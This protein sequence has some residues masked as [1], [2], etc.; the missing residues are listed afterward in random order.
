MDPGINGIDCKSATFNRPYIS[1]HGQ[2][3]ACCWVTGSDEEATFLAGHGLTPGRYNIH[4]RPL[5]EILVD[6][7]FARL[8]ARAWAADSLATCRHKCGK[9]LRNKPNTLWDGFRL[10][11][12][13]SPSLPPAGGERR[14]VLNRGPDRRS[15]PCPGVRGQS[16]LPTPG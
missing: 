7:P 15:S 5:E 12:A 16:S 6:E 4:N 10:S 13:P 14:P 1:A 3:S 2:V 11:Y 8:Y 9:M